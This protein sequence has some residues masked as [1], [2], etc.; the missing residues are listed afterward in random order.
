MLVLLSPAKTLDMD[1]S[2]VGLSTVPAALDDA[3]ELIQTMRGYS[4]GDVQSLMKL[5]PKL[6]ELNVNRYR[7]YERPAV[8]GDGS[9][10]ALLAF[11]GDVYRDWP[12][13]DYSPEDFEY[14]Q[15]HIRILS[16]LY[17]VLRPMDLIRPYRLEMGTRLK[18]ERGRN[19]YDFW[20]ERVTPLLNQALAE[21]GSDDRIV[22]NLASNEYFGAVRPE[23]LDGTL[24]TP[25]FKDN[26]NGK[27]KVISFYAK[28]ARGQMAHFVVKNRVETLKALHG[29]ELMGYRWDEPSST[30]ANPVF[31]RG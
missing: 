1:P 24:V 11:K 13:A 21:Q 25:T 27:Y 14:A 15:R 7:D 31:L 28:R 5:S 9:K 17:G 19:L 16:G 6:A 23:A 8:L 22:L 4:V 30:P 18:T 29:F 26:K 3:D 2:P 10:Q 12:H 20:A